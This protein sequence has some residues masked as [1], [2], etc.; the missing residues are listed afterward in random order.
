MKKSKLER[1]ENDN[2]KRK[3]SSP[4]KVEEQTKVEN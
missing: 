2:K 4:G 1:R 3:E